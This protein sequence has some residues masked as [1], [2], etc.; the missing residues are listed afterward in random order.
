VHSGEKKKNV[1]GRDLATKIYSGQKNTLIVSRQNE[2]EGSG[3]EYCGRCGLFCLTYV[4]Y[5]IA[6]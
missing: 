5:V 6:E 2:T 3:G 4:T 1:N